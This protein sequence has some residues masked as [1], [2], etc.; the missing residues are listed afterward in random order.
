M[1]VPALSRR[2]SPFTDCQRSAG[3]KT[4]PGSGRL[5][6]TCGRCGHLGSPEVHS[7]VEPSLCIRP[8]E[9]GSSRRGFPAPIASPTLA[10]S[11]AASRSVAGRPTPRT[12]TARTARRM[13]A[14][15]SPMGAALFATSLF[16]AA[17]GRRRR[18][19]GRRPGA[20]AARLAA[21]VEG[22]RVGRGAA[23]G[24][25]HLLRVLLVALRAHAR[26]HNGRTDGR[27][28]GGRWREVSA[29][30]QARGNGERA[31]ALR[32]ARSPLLSLPTLSRSD[33]CA[34]VGGSLLAR[35]P[36]LRVRGRSGVGRIEALGEDGLALPGGGGGTGR[37]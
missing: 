10:A 9:M 35:Q 28:E 24:A 5:M 33:L 37:R 20:A 11:A 8:V 6:P 22:G 23:L 21:D 14:C 15:R 31:C 18:R 30:A 1:D 3:P 36:A 25:A 32:L 13:R 26:A 16:L 29:C 27:T 17:G 4:R 2:L 12:R 19:R 7:E 34:S